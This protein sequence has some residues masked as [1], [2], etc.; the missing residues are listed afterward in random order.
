MHRLFPLMIVLA[1]LVTL[2]VESLGFAIA[3]SMGLMVITLLIAPGTALAFASIDASENTLVAI[4]AT[5]TALYYIL[6]LLGIRRLSRA[7]RQGNRDQT[8]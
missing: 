1:V 6:I 4:A 2:L 8:R 3:H 5:I 7:R